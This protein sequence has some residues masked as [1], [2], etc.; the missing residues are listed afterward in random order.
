MNTLTH[1]HMHAPWAPVSWAA[2]RPAGAAV[3]AW[4]AW[5][6]TS[7]ARGQ[8]RRAAARRACRA[9]PCRHPARLPG[10]PGAA[11]HG[12]GRGRRG[13]GKLRVTDGGTSN[14]RGK[15]AEQCWKQAAAT[16]AAHALCSPPSRPCPIELALRARL[17]R[18]CRSPL[19]PAAS[20]PSSGCRS[21]WISSSSSSLPSSRLRKAREKNSTHAWH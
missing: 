12:G 7:R 1:S 2:R 14:A 21:S 4:A 16:P 19:V 5:Q 15:H 9:P 17:I 18:L 6:T 8:W 13:A 11:G 10:P 20:S 3:A